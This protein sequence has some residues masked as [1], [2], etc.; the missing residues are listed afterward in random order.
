MNV[1]AVHVDQESFAYKTCEFDLG[2]MVGTLALA[3]H[4]GAREG[5][6]EVAD[7]A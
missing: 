1:R 3:V 2:R 6:G 4:A 5:R 7:K